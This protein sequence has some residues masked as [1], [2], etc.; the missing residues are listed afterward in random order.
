MSLTL[1]FSKSAVQ[2]IGQYYQLLRFGKNGYRAV[3]QNL[4]HTSDYLAKEV[5][6]IG[7]GKLFELM[8]DTG[9]K[10]LP[11]VAWR[12]KKDSGAAF[13]EFAIAHKLRERGWIVP[14]YHMAPHAHEVKMLRVVCREGTSRIFPPCLCKPSV[15]DHPRSSRLQQGSVQ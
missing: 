13:D 5:V 4:I 1:N 2:V 12:I 11:L 15:I 8:S 10:G 7:E 6:D 14:A 9:G 3:M